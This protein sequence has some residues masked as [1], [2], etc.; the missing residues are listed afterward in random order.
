MTDIS[1]NLATVR[2]SIAQFAEEFDRNAAAIRLVAVSKTR[3]P[4]DIVAALAAGQCDFGENY[5]QEALP[6]IATLAGTGARWHYIG[7]IQSN[8]S[9]DLATHF[10]WVQTV[11]REKVAQRL[12]DLRPESLPALN[13]CIQVN[14]GREPQKSGVPPESLATLARAM[15]AM[16]RL[17]LRGLMT[18]PPDNSDFEAQ[19]RAFAELH[20]LYTDLRQEGFALDTLSMGMSGDLRAAIAEGS[21]MVRVGTAIFGIRG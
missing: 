4:G 9:R 6:K 19:R 5:L 16:P 13:V 8:K 15:R 11:D 17:A 14:V 7:R 20:G 21:T 3:P 1:A 18:V 2:N 10:D 12:N